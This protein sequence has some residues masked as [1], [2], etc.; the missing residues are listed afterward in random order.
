MDVKNFT[1]KYL[2]LVWFEMPKL[3]YIKKVSSLRFSMN[4]KLVSFCL[5]MENENSNVKAIIMKYLMDILNL[6]EPTEN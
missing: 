6:F 4:V 1:G 2:H 3:I 5:K